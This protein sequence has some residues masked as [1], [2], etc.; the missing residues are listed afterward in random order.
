[1]HVTEGGLCGDDEEPGFY[2]KYLGGVALHAPGGASGAPG[3]AGLVV[4]SSAHGLVLFSDLEGGPALPARAHNSWQ[5]R[6]MRG[7]GSGGSRAAMILR[8]CGSALHPAVR[9]RRVRPAHGGHAR[10]RQQGRA[11]RA[12]FSARRGRCVQLACTHPGRHAAG[13]VFRRQR[14]VD[15]AGRLRRRH[16]LLLPTGQHSLWVAPAAL[17]AASARRDAAA[18][19]PQRHSAVSAGGCGARPIAER[20]QLRRRGQPGAVRSWRCPGG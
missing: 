13:L 11:E 7:S 6:L 17:G 19:E 12:L 1:M 2:F 14:A 5:G 20:V 10:S 18:V 15:A 3:A 16:G 9:R 8:C 4:A